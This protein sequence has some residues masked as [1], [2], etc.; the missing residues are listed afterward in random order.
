MQTLVDIIG[1][2]DQQTKF[3]RRIKQPVDQIALDVLDELGLHDAPY[4][5]KIIL[6][7]NA[8]DVQEHYA[9]KYPGKTLNSHSYASRGGKE[10]YVSVAD[11]TLRSLAHELAHVAL[12]HYFTTDKVPNKLHELIA[13][14]V[15][16]RTCKRYSKWF[17]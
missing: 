14:A 10:C 3:R 1:T 13:Q 4:R 2:S 5:F 6:R 7:G 8:Q 17:W 9:S 11:V 15:E 16:E 12:N